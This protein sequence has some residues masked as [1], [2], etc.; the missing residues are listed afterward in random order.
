MSLCPVDGTAV[1][2][3][4]LFKREGNAMRYVAFVEIMAAALRFDFFQAGAR[5]RLAAHSMRG[6]LL[7]LRYPH[8]PSP[9]TQKASS[10]QA[11]CPRLGC[12]APRHVPPVPR[13]LLIALRS[14]QVHPRPELDGLGP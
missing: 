5:R 2:W 13:P 1:M 7:L 10:R 9:Q 12:C 3:P 4:H 11:V 6:R 14:G 8:W